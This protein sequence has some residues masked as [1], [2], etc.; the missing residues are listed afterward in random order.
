VGERKGGKRLLGAN[1]AGR[2]KIV[3]ER[4]HMTGLGARESLISV[5]VTMDLKRSQEGVTR[6][7]NEALR[8]G[9]KREG[10]GQEPNKKRGPFVEEQ[11]NKDL[12]PP[13]PF[14]IE[15]MYLGSG[16]E[17]KKKR[18]IDETTMAPM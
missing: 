11:N 14:V 7:M 17:K 16:G 13:L 4:K 18:K 5:A 1:V 3:S 6:K 12:G 9:S 8:R 10:Q 15:K 2:K